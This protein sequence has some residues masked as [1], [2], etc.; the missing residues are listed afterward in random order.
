MSSRSISCGMIY[1]RSRRTTG[2]GTNRHHDG[3]WSCDLFNIDIRSD[4]GLFWMRAQVKMGFQSWTRMQSESAFNKNRNSVHLFLLSN[5]TMLHI[6]LLIP[7][8]ALPDIYIVP[9]T[10]IGPSIPVIKKKNKKKKGGL[11]T[12]Y[13]WPRILRKIIIPM[14]EQ[15]KRKK[16]KKKKKLNNRTSCI[17][18]K[19]TAEIG[20][21][22]M[23][24][25][26]RA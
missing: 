19:R 26:L 9:E 25:I 3:A 13:R 1:P 14:Q 5:L 21:G 12:T 7:W 2:K 17:S 23:A 6:Y 16:K 22:Q 15:Q 18:Q 20:Q 11:A 4:P 8:S 24:G 10:I